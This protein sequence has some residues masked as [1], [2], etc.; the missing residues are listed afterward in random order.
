[1]K[2]YNEFITEGIDS[3][4]TTTQLSLLSKELHTELVINSKYSLRRQKTPKP[5]VKVLEYIVPNKFKLEIELRNKKFHTAEWLLTRPD[6]TAPQSSKTFINEKKLISF[7]KGLR[8]K[9]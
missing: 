2:T 4:K 3:G 9:R 6:P 7:L 5:G 1:M 8:G